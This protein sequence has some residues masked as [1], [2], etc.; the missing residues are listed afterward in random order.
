MYVC[1]IVTP[2]LIALLS[3]QLVRTGSLKF[4]LELLRRWDGRAPAP[5]VLRADRPRTCI[6]KC[7]RIRFRAVPRDEGKERYPPSRRP[8]HGARQESTGGPQQTPPRHQTPDESNGENAPE[9]TDP[10]A[11][12]RTLNA[13][14]GVESRHPHTPRQH[15][16]DQ[17][18]DG[19][20]VPLVLI[21][22]IQQ[23]HNVL[24]GE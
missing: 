23:T 15:R 3:E 19:V 24:A 16:Q 9:C 7:S 1:F 21:A 20:A 10:E 4:G 11:L 2:P 13:C 8:D 18:R 17:D 22:V 14:Q 6:R 5:A 12:T